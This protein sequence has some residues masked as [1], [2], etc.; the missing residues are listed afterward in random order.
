MGLTFELGCFG[1]PNNDWELFFVQGMQLGGGSAPVY[2]LAGGGDAARARTLAEQQ[3]Q[4]LLQMQRSQS[5]LVSPE[6][7]YP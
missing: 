3:R 5:M 2:G 7:Q 4:R 6:V 1:Y